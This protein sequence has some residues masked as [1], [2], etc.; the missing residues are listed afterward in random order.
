MPEASCRRPAP[1]RPAPFRRRVKWAFL[2]GSPVGG[3]AVGVVGA[4]FG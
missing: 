4:G 1:A 2:T 3:T